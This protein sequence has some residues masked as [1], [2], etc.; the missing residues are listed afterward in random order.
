[1]II[2]A[3]DP[4]EATA[5]YSWFSN[6]S[7]IKKIGDLGWK[8][9]LDR[10]NLVICKSEALS[11]LLK[12]ELPTVSGGIA[13]YTVLSD[14]ISATAKFFSDNK[15]EFIQINDDL[16]ALQLPKSIGGYVF[17]GKDESVFPWSD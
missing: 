17:I 4:D 10:G 3:K 14:N 6:K 1:M 9:P 13:G 7:S 5:R 15:I 2:S 12:S 8:I 11:S 16:L